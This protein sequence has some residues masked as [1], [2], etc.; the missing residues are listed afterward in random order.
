[1]WLPIQP[2]TLRGINS[3]VG[4]PD[5]G[6]R[7][8]SW[9][10]PYPT[11]LWCS[12]ASPL[13]TTH[14]ARLPDMTPGITWL[15]AVLTQPRVSIT[16]PAAPNGPW[17]SLLT[18]DAHGVASRLAMAMRTASGAESKFVTYTTS[19]SARCMAIAIAMTGLYPGSTPEFQVGWDEFVAAPP[20]PSLTP[21]WG[22]EGERT[23][24]LAFTGTVDADN[25]LPFHH[26]LEDALRIRA[27]LIDPTDRHEQLDLCRL[28]QPLATWTP[29]ALLSSSSGLLLE[30]TAVTMALRA[31]TTA[32]EFTAASSIDGRIRLTLF[33][34]QLTGKVL[35][36]RLIN[37]HTVSRKA[38][39]SGP[40]GSYEVTA[41]P[42][43]TETLDI[44]AGLLSLDNISYGTSQA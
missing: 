32:C 10:C 15:L 11:L 41:A 20:Y 27:I 23:T 42:G 24:W 25:D 22:V 44:S 29:S 43:A 12:T 30:C 3:T 37:G 17:T 14:Q 38:T 9:G 7:V 13:G 19:A 36:M 33:L 6:Y 8:R 40:G 16:W 4:H 34:H 31:N 39:V 26:A 5:G 35:T 28:D 2:F 1:M 21:S 18:G